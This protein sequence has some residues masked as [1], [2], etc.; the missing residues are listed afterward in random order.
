MSHEA[1]RETNLGDWECPSCNRKV[2]EP[3]NLPPPENLA[4]WRGICAQH[5]PDCDWCRQYAPGELFKGQSR[6]A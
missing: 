4:A 2:H 5:E 3:S 1:K 6:A